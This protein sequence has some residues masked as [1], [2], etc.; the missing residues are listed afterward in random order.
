[1][2]PPGPATFS[3][4]VIAGFTPTSLDPTRLKIA[5]GTPGLVCSD[6]ASYCPEGAAEV[7]G[8][9]LGCGIDLLVGAGHVAVPD[10]Y[11]PWPSVL[12]RC[13]DSTSFNDWPALD[14]QGARKRGPHE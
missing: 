5:T 13:L 11:G 2:S 3:W 8:R 6:N 14:G 4:D 10:G 12:D 7:F 9:P 1:M